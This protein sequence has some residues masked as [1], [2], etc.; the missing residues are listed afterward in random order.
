MLKIIHPVA[1]GGILLA[2]FFLTN[3]SSDGLL[4]VVGGGLSVF[5]SFAIDLLK[6]ES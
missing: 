5:T 1:V 2:T 4:G 6:T 3:G